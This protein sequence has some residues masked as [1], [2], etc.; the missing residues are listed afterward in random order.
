V[1]SR[2]VELVKIIDVWEKAGAEFAGNYVLQRVPSLVVVDATQLGQEVTGILVQ[3]NGPQNGLNDP[4][5][6][7]LT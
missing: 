5:S 3:A 6:R 4:C 1:A 2:K 7:R